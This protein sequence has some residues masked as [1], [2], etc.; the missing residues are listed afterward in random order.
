MKRF[1]T[2][3]LSLLIIVLGTAFAFADIAPM[4]RRD[5]AHTLA[6]IVAVVIIIVAIVFLR[7]MIK[8]RRLKNDGI[9]PEEPN[10]INVR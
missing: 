10:D 5:S 1:R 2:L 9:Q 3:V 8:R 7:A 6:I 4:P